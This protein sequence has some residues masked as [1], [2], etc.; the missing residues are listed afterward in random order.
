[1]VSTAVVDAANALTWHVDSVAVPVEPPSWDIGTSNSLLSAHVVAHN[2]F[3]SARAAEDLARVTTKPTMCAPAAKRQ[4]EISSSADA[5]GADPPGSGVGEEPLLTVIPSSSNK[6]SRRAR[7]P[8][9]STAGCSASGGKLSVRKP[10]I[11]GLRSCL[12]KR[13]HDGILAPS[14]N[15]DVYHS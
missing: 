15:D 7:P 3:V 4:R 11:H 1:V 14:V 8:A 6:V 13:M 2:I 10:R 9:K 5:S 12:T